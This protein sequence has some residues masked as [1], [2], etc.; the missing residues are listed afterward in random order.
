MKQYLTENWL[1]SIQYL[2]TD[3]IYQSA[4]KQ[5]QGKENL[6]LAPF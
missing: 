5:K 6:K 4:E 2:S 3:G 1:S